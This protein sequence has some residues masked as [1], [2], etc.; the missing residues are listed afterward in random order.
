MN[1]QQ[2]NNPKP[3]KTC[4]CYCQH[5]SFAN[6]GRFRE[7]TLSFQLPIWMLEWK[8]TEVVWV[9]CAEYWFTSNFYLL[10]CVYEGRPSSSSLFPLLCI[11]SHLSGAGG[12]GGVQSEC[13]HSH[14]SALLVSNGQCEP[15]VLCLQ[16]CIGSDL[17][18]TPQLVRTVNCGIR[19]DI[20]F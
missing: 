1:K 2:Q 11:T 15:A 13:A 7:C 20:F 6:E 14:L 12:L 9:S 4:S 16:S 10:M 8:M 5:L 19:I 17:D 3:P 18:F